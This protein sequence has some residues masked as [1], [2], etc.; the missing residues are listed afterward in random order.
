MCAQA[1]QSGMSLLS[2][3]QESYIYIQNMCTYMSAGNMKRAELLVQ[4]MEPPSRN[5]EQLALPNEDTYHILADGWQRAGVM[6][7]VMDRRESLCMCVY[8][9]IRM[10][11]CVCMCVCVCSRSHV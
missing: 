8:V 1:I 5:R 9:Y 3:K 6:Y 11:M 10:C 4:E 2:W 7:D